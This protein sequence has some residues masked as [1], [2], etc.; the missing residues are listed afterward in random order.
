MT[1]SFENIVVVWFPEYEVRDFVVPERDYTDFEKVEIQTA[2][3]EKEIAGWSITLKLKNTGT[4]ASTLIGV[5]VNDV[6]IM[7]DNYGKTGIIE[8]KVST[9]IENTGITFNS[10][11]TIQFHVWISTNYGTLSSGTTINIKLHS[12]DGMDYIKLLELV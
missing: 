9:D 3:C 1:T 6:E 7:Q 11:Q 4:V 5:L 8:G 2:I 10:G 12:A